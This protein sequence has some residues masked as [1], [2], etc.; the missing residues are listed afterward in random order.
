[1]SITKRLV[2]RIREPLWKPIRTWLIVWMTRPI[3]NLLFLTRGSTWIS[4]ERVSCILFM[5]MATIPIVK[6]SIVSWKITLKLEKITFQRLSSF[7]LGSQTKIRNS[8]IAP[9][10]RLGNTSRVVF[11]KLM[12]T[13]P[14]SVEK[15]VWI[16]WLICCEGKIICPLLIKTWCVQDK[17]PSTL[18]PQPVYL[19]NIRIM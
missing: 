10:L 6:N 3:S 17:Q 7:L 5:R 14:S 4:L 2:W 8:L 11:L 19:S 13:L 16:T 18:L 15:A 1:M 12:R 9:C